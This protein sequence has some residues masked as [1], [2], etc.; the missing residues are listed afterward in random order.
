MITESSHKLF[1]DEE[2]CNI[3]YSKINSKKA[4]ILQ[5]C[6]LS[7]EQALQ[8]RLNQSYHFSMVLNLTLAHIRDT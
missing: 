4:S 3:E 2:K 5:I 7:I 1:I 8:F 6:S